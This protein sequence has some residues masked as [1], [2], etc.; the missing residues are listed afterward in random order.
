MLLILREVPCDKGI[1]GYHNIVFFHFRE[2]RGALG[3]CSHD[4]K[5]PQFRREFF[6]LALPVQHQRSL[7]YDKASPPLERFSS[8]ISAIAC[9]V[10]PSPI[11]SARIPPRPYA[12]SVFSHRN[13]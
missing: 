13:P 12:D 2:L 7:T 8:S 3:S 1:G 11:S 10:F 9:N 4:G 5:H 6:N